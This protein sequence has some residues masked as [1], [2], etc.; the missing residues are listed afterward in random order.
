MIGYLRGEVAAVSEGKLILDV[1]DVGFMI[2]VTSKDASLMPSAGNEVK[3]YTHLQV[4]EDDMQLYGFLTQ[5][6]LETFRLLLN[7]NGIGPKAALGILSVLSSDDLRFAVLADDVK[8]ISRAPGIGNKTAQK[9]IL[10]LKDKM[11]LEDAFEK[12]L[13]NTKENQA[14]LASPSDD[15]KNE[16]VLALTALGYSNS[17][18][19]RAVRQAEVT[20]GMDVEEILKAALKHLSFL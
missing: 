4:K 17:D 14:A 20:D 11:S 5:D 8:A 1:H 13:A 7:V 10:E 18:S 2:S 6:D 9:L 12:K 16:A 19:L 3:I 15:A